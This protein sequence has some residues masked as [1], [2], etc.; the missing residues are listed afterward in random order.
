MKFSAFSLNLAYASSQSVYASYVNSLCA[1][2]LAL[3]LQIKCCQHYGCVV[4]LARIITGRAIYLNAYLS[5][6]FRGY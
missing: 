4:A 1:S 5:P 2:R 3:F 6:S